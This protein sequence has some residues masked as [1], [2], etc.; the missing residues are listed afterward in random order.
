MEEQIKGNK[1]LAYKLFIDTQQDN[2]EYIYRGQFNTDI[3]DNILSLAEE[4]LR[5][6]EQKLKIKKRVYFVMVEGLQNITRHQDL[7]TDDIP[8]KPGFFVL[9]RKKY[10]YYITTGNLIN[11]ENIDVLKSQINKVQSLSIEELNIYY[12]QHLKD[13]SM[14]KKGGAGLGLI[15]MARKSKGNLSYNFRKI[16]DEYYYFYLL[17]EI[18]FEEKPEE[19]INGESDQSLEKIIELH[20]ILNIES[21]ALNY[22]GLFNQHSLV[23]LLGIIEKQMKGTVLLRTKTFNIMVELLQN[24]VKHS[25]YY[26]I[27]EIGGHYGIFFITENAENFI[28]TTGNFIKSEKVPKLKIHIDKVNVFDDK[29]LNEWYNDLLLGPSPSEDKT[30][31][32]L[33]I[34]DLKL[35]SQNKLDYNFQKVDDEFHFYSIRAR[36]N[37]FHEKQEAFI[38]DESFEKPSIKFIPAKNKFVIKGRSLPSNAYEFYLPVLNWVDDYFKNPNSITV[39]EFKFEHLNT[40]SSHQVFKLLKKIKEYS[41]KAKVQVKWYYKSE[42]KDMGTTAV[43]FRE[44]LDMEIKLVEEEN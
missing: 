40:H 34:I 9:Q 25:A 21:I 6:S 38:S 24:L 29:K 32:G 44:L 17:T 41:S 35:R 23:N 1:S 27:N 18:P 37:K 5:L 19:T 30:G 4:S 16:N 2:L 7:T 20:N 26:V 13:G 10:S 15:E 11:I 14:S 39:F 43:R 42:D 28:L 22:S 3:T 36:V 33:G 31:S 12:K 8:V